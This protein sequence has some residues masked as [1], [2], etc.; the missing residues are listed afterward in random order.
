[1]KGGEVL[2]DTNAAKTFN[3]PNCGGQMVFD[4]KS[5][6]M[7]C[8]YCE[9]EVSLADDREVK[10]YDFN[11]I[12]DHHVLWDE[13]VSVLQCSM[14][15]AEMIVSHLETATKCAY[16]NSTQVFPNKQSA[17]IKP[18]G[19][20]PFKV[21]SQEATLIMEKWMKRRWLAPRDL[22]LLYQSDIM[23]GMYV[24]Y[25]TYDADAHAH[26]TGQ[27]GDYYYVTERNS[28]GKEVR[29]Q[30][31]RWHYVSGQLHRLFDD[32]LVT[33]STTVDHRI[34]N[35][36]DGF[37][38]EAVQP[39]NESYLAG[40]F[41]QRYSKDVKSC[42]S[43]AK[44]QMQKTL[45]N[46]AKQDILSHYDTAAQIVVRPTFSDVSYKHVLLPVWMAT[47]QYKNKTYQY[48]I[49]GQTGTVNGSFPYS[50][51]KIILLLILAG[52]VLWWLLQS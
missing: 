35:Q 41:A 27:G 22:K 12:D 4:I 50:I 39:Y 30:K 40:F 49:N 11:T 19:V 16:C 31:V 44:Q 5:Q 48:M 6:N 36:I 21:N 46:D 32:V 8:M 7:K 52:L 13:E 37:N 47:Y 20:L 14:C 1:M 9:A 18:E 34:I 26:Y 2:T 28:E 51:I 3:C 42:F 15:G 45:E 38:T 29:V 24:P 33:A 17:G 23:R 25:W 43:E 10:E